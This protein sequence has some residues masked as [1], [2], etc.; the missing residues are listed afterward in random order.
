MSVYNSE[1]NSPI[2]SDDDDDI[3]DS[4]TRISKLDISDPLHLHPNDTIVLTVVSIKLKG[5][6][7]YQVWSCAMLLALEGKNKIG[8]IDC[9]CKRSNINEVLGK[10]WERNGSSIADYYHKLNALWK[11]YD[12]MVELSKCVCNA[13]EEVLPD[14]RSAY[15]TISSEESHRVAVGSVAGSSQ[16]NQASAFVS[17][18]LNSQNFQRS[19]QNFI[20][21]PSRSNNLNNNRQSGGSGLDWTSNGNLCVK[22]MHIILGWDHN[23]VDV[24]VISQTD[25]VI[26]TRVWMKVEKKEVFCTFVYAHNKYTRRRDLW[27]NLGVHRHYVRNRP[28]CLLGDFN[29]ALYLEDSTAGSSR[30]DIAMRE[31]KECVHD[32]EVMDIQSTGLH[33]TWNQKPKGNDGILKKIDWVMCNLEFSSAFV[34][35][36]A[37]FQPYRVSDHSLAIL[38][39]PAKVLVKARPFKFTNILTQHARFMEVVNARWSMYTSGFFMFRVVQKLKELKKPFRQ[40]LFDKGNLHENV[41]RL[42]K[43]LDQVQLDLDKD[44]FNSILREEEATYVQAFNDAIIEEERF[45]KQKAKIQWLREGDSNSAYFH[46]AVKGRV[47]R[48][49]INVVTNSLGNVFYNDQVAGAF[50]SHYEEFLGQ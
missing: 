42:R 25:Q 34:G 2:N 4:V 15:A 30:L 10:Q 6:E 48:S 16:R 36:H 47:S 49:R 29:V 11:Q 1:H 44:P 19:N 31:F 14:V 43:E 27:H 32:I 23:E 3:H 9:S 33:F 20:T 45:M 22:G 39:I 21:G 35:S 26:H 38:N 12:V 46:K 41:R 7:N 8:F 18:V 28:W 50:V 13:S 17:N 37:I 40:L 24:A 5:T